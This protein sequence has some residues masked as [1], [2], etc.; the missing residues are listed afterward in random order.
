MVSDREHVTAISVPSRPGGW[1][2]DY[3][4]PTDFSWQCY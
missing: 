4:A 2:P 1:V 3:L